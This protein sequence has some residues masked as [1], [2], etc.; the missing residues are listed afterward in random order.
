MHITFMSALYAFFF[1]PKRGE[2]T[3]ER[4]TVHNEELQDLYS[5]PNIIRVI[6]TRSMRWVGHVT[7]ME[8]RY[9]QSVGGE[10]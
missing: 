9:I 2:V 8:E 7:R 6:K 1:L 10:R 4:R 5:S 3:R